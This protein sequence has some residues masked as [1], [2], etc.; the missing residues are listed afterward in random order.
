[1]RMM[2]ARSLVAILLSTL[3]GQSVAQ[4]NTDV[5]LTEEQ[6]QDM[7]R[8]HQ[9]MLKLKKSMIQRYVE[10]GVYTEEKGEKIISYLEKRFTKLE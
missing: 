2:S 9:E 6:K 3:P 1:M 5:T 7:L 8:L 4:E 10:Y